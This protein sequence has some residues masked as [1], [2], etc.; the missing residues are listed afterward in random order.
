MD[1]QVYEELVSSGV[2]VTG[3][4]VTDM[5]LQMGQHQ[6]GR[7]PVEGEDSCDVDLFV[8]WWLY[9]WKGGHATR[10]TDQVT[11]VAHLISA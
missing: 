5:A 6:H 2:T 10:M 1:G 3:S 9:T 7:G 4:T 8:D 11:T